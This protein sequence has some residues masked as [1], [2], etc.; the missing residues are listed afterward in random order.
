MSTLTSTIREYLGVDPPS[1]LY[2]YTD[3]RGLLGIIQSRALWLTDCAYLN[4]TAELTYADSL[5]RS[6]IQEI[7]ASGECDVGMK[8]YL[9]AIDIPL[10][11]NGYVSALSASFSEA[12]DL[13]SQWRAYCPPGGGYSIGF[14]SNFSHSLDVPCS[15]IL[16]PCVYEVERQKC[17]L[18]AL[19]EKSLKGNT[20]SADSFGMFEILYRVFRPV[21]KHPSFSEEKEWRLLSMDPYETIKAIQYRPKASFVV[22]YCQVAFRPADRLPIE[23]VVVGPCRSPELAATS[24]HRMLQSYGLPDTVVRISSSTWRAG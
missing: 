8:S 4:D 3:S 7:E 22:P 16:R 6:L 15:L 18:R 19:L 23:E 21:M 13:L 11:S 17:I 2:H 9:R 5:V 24:V 10:G 12:G 14:S 20:T 1:I